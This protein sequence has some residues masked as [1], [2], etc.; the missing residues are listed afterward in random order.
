MQLEVIEHERIK[1]SNS[2]DLEKK[3][4][5]YNDAE[6]LKKVEDKQGKQIFRWGKNY[7]TPAHWVGIISTPKITI[8]ILPK[9]TDGDNKKEIKNIL[10]K[11][12][13]IANDIPTRKNIEANISYGSQGFIDILAAIFLRELEMQIHKGLISSYNKTQ[14]NLNSV[15]GSID[16]TNNIRRNT[17]LVNKFYCKFSILTEDNK[18][19]RV[20]KYTLSILSK[21]VKRQDNKRL[22]KKLTSYFDQVK[23][24]P[25]T[26]DTIK[27]IHLDRI[28]MR[29]K[30][31]LKYCE[32]F[33]SGHTLD[34]VTGKVKVDF[35]LFDMNNLFEKYVFKMYKKLYKNVTYQK[36]TQKLLKN[37]NGK[38]KK[39]NLRP[40]IVL[41]TTSTTVIIDTKWKQVKSFAEVNDIYQINT[42]L[43]AFPNVSQ[44]VLLYPK[45]RDND[46]IRGEYSF[47]NQDDTFRLRIAT[48]D[49]M[50]LVDR[51]A[52]FTDLKEI[53]EEIT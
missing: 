49:L 12:L 30:E 8:D 38:G 19:N 10:I 18:L 25:V 16:F 3:Q 50:K 42:Y 13:K 44:A 21:L 48:I 41:K 14:R 27:N 5:S 34:M 1:I 33:V 28:S 15:K 23:V 53:V 45:T 52:F 40:D 6:F 2:T 17:L 46:K 11:M 9:I 29:Y 22:V 47:I 24:T 7:V 37:I 32:L 20:I 39:I 51:Q 26:I 31:V 36:G 43:N 35:L 4:I